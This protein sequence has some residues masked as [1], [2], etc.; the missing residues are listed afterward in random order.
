MRIYAN[1]VRELQTRILKM[2]EFYAWGMA[3][4]SLLGLCGGKRLKN[5]FFII[6]PALMFG[7]FFKELEME[8]ICKPLGDWGYCLLVFACVVYGG[9]IGHIFPNPGTKDGQ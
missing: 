5:C 1:Q 6:A 9:V 8:V 7:V 3:A 2:N 4:S